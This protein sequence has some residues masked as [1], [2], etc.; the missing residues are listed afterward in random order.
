MPFSTT[1]R[2][3]ERKHAVLKLLSSDGCKTTTQ[4]MKTL[5]LTHSEAYYVLEMLKNEGHI[6][7]GVFGRVAIWC[8]NDDQFKSTISELMQEIHRIVE[9]CKLKYVYPMRIYRLILNDRKAYALLS[10]YVPFNSNISATLAFLNAIL[11]MLYGKPY[12][13]GEKTVYLTTLSTKTPNPTP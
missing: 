11:E 9:S 4:I 10:R 8:L 13:V 2:I 7:K 12:F 3:K 1:R 5:G 6:V